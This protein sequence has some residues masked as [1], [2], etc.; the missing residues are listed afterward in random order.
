VP[1]DTGTGTQT[2]DYEL[3]QQRLRNNDLYESIRSD[4]VKAAHVF[5]KEFDGSVSHLIVPRRDGTNT[6]TKGSPG[7]VQFLY[8]KQ[9]RFKSFRQVMAPVF[10]DIG[11]GTWH[12]IKGLLIKIYPFIELKNRLKCSAADNGFMRASVLIQPKTANVSQRMSLIQIGAMTLLPPSSEYDLPQVQLG[13]SIEE[14]LLLDRAFDNQ[15]SSNIGMYRP[16]VRKEQ[17]NPETATK[18]LADQAK[19]AML[20]KGAVNRWYSQMDFVGEE[21]F[22]RMA[23]SK[24]NEDNGGPNDM[25]LDFQSRCRERGVPSSALKK[26]IVRA[27]R[28]IGNGSIFMRKQAIT[29]LLPWAGLMPEAGKQNLLD[30]TIAITANQDFVARYNPKRELETATADERAYAMLENGVL[31]SGAPVARTGTQN[32][33][34]HAGTHLEAGAQAAGSLEQGANPAE[35]AA[36][37]DAIG[38]HTAQH[39]QPLA[40]NPARKQEFTLL[41]KQWQ[42]LAKIAD[43][44][45]KMLMQQAQEQQ[46]A[47]GQQQQMITDAQLDEQKMQLDAQRKDEKQ[48]HDMRRKEVAARQKLVINDAMA[49]NKINNSRT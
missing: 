10:F 36:Y 26:A 6:S 32:D 46:Q 37:L 49:A 4:V 29:E 12:S 9:A 43:G 1:E 27:F 33:V 22:R 38:Q 23:N 19:E 15:L 31:K 8:K 20:N 5:V 40:G 21:I 11:D 30:D 14:T 47:Q 44:L 28:N 17:G 48:A 16:T 3:C 35:V 7:N 39:L 25:A 2:L 34:I 24:L 42:E 18:V 41:Q 13:G 45:N